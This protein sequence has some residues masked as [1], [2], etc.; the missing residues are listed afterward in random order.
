MAPVP[1]LT[2]ARCVWRALCSGVVANPQDIRICAL[3]FKQERRRRPTESQSGQPISPT[4][5]KVPTSRALQK[6]VVREA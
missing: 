4:P 1:L 5:A 6:H 2:R 3:L